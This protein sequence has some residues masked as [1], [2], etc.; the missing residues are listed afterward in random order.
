VV[1]IGSKNRAKVQGAKKAFLRV[2]PDAKFSQTDLTPRVKLQPLGLGETVSG[3]RQ[4]A[5]LAIKERGADFGVG[6]EAGIIKLPKAEGQ[7]FFLNVQIAA[8][9]DRAGHLSFGSSSGFPLP[10]RFVSLLEDKEAE[11]DQYALEL[12]GA[13]KIREEDGVVYHLSKAR[14]SRMEMTEQCVSMALIPWLNKEAFQ[15]G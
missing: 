15:F 8:I 1:A 12:T 11:L 5:E 3:A 13:E 7:D 14:L 9:V 6:V 2:F 10:S 4:R